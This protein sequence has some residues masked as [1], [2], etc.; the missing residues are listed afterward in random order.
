M[1]EDNT[2]RS[3]VEP[4]QGILSVPRRVLILANLVL[5]INETS[6]IQETMNQANATAIE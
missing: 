1:K 6:I 4:I 3:A 2:P 5:L